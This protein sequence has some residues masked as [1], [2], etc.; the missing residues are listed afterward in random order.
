MAI[1]R[2]TEMTAER[3]RIEVEKNDRMSQIERVSEW[4]EKQPAVE[5]NQSFE[6]LTIAGHNPNWWL[7]AIYRKMWCWCTSTSSSIYSSCFSQL[8]NVFV[9]SVWLI[10]AS[11]V[12]QQPANGQWILTA[13]LDV[14]APDIAQTTVESIPFSHSAVALILIFPSHDE[15]CHLFDIGDRTHYTFAIESLVAAMAFQLF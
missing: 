10:F 12:R 11:D 7:L 4:N 13:R 5:W 14:W 15:N 1:A 6:M 9:H 2:Q 3:Q 8:Y